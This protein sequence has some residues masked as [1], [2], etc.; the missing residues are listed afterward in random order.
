MSSVQ[1][2]LLI[3]L[4]AINERSNL[5]VL[6]PKLRKELPFAQLL[7]IDDG[8]LDGTNE[9]MEKITHSDTRIWFES[10]PTRLGIGSAHLAGLEK[11]TTK[12]FRFV[13]TMDS[14]Q[15]HRVQ[16]AKSLWEFRNSAPLVIGSRYLKNSKII[17]WSAFR[18]LLTYAG[19]ILTLIS[20][21][22]KLDMSSGLRVYETK[23]IPLSSLK[24]NCPTDYEY[25]FSSI[26]VYSKLGI[27][28]DQI[29]ITLEKRGAGKSKMTFKLMRQ[30]IRRLLV[31]A[32][33]VR[34]ISV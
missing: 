2:D 11:A 17:G 1:Q 14:D 24:L 13:M 7:V 16:D 12:N 19:H 29:P 31:Y 9:L 15:T 32:L 6:L 10:R 34:K 30:G 27:S 26:L 22:S 25:F 23:R 3:I 28:I 4:P 8:S 33:R 18:I 5:E 21:Q 20:F